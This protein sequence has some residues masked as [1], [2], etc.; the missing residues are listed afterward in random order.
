MATKY[1]PS[2]A[3]GAPPARL[4]ERVQELLGQ[5]VVDWR[6]PDTGLSPALRYLV[7]LA[8]RSLAFVKAA[9]SLETTGWLRNEHAAMQYVPQFAPATLAWSDSGG[10]HPLLI[11]EALTG[12]WPA[13]HAGVVWRPG[14]LDRVMDALQRLAAID[15]P[16][17]LETRQ[18]EATFGWSRIREQPGAFL[19]LGLCSGSWLDAHGTALLQAEESLRRDGSTFVHGDMRSDNICLTGTGPRFV[20]WSRA[21]AGAAGTDLASF[22]PATH[23]E[24][25]PPPFELAPDAFTWGAAQA[26]ELIAR[27]SDGDELP[28]WL[29]RVLRRLAA[30]NLDWAVAGMHL[31]RRDGPSW[32]EM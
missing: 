20:D 14:D 5:P 25:G 24:G 16:A 26:A 28:P 3:Q 30:I 22:L 29:R 13:S 31:P 11:C 7:T 9:T 18:P 19:A 8:D 6:R 21:G 32:A 12:H 27:L 10:D 2:S 15:P 17:H 1:V 4:Q 23:L